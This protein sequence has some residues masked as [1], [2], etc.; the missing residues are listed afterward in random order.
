[1]KVL[2]VSSNGKFKNDA[3]RA[4]NGYEF[5]MARLGDGLM[6]LIKKESPDLI[7][8]YKEKRCN[9]VSIL[10]KQY[11]EIPLLVISDDKNIEMK[12]D[13]LEQG[14]DSYIHFSF[15]SEKLFAQMKALIR[16]FEWQRLRS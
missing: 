13:C 2:C 4:K 1:M 3:F 14:A 16:G 11:P 15:I 7:L 8:L 12:I 6:K 5:V 10:K 9:G